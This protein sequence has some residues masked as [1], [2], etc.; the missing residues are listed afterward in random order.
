MSSDRRAGS[1]G[2]ATVGWYPGGI[3]RRVPSTRMRT[4]LPV[5]ALRRAG[6][7]ASV[8]LRTDVAGLDCVVFQ[9]AYDAPAIEWARRLRVSG[10]PTVFDLC[11]DHFDNPDDD[12][13]LRERAERLRTM[14][15]LVD[16]VT[17]SVPG[18]VSVVGHP[19]VHVVD[20]ALEFLPSA[21][22][23][24]RWAPWWRARRSEREIR[25][26]W[27]G[28]SG[29]VSPRTGM[30]CIEDAIP[31]LERLHRDRPVRLRVISNSRDIFDRHVARAA[32][33][34]EYREW[35][36]RGFVRSFVPADVCVIPITINASTLKKTANRVR[37][38]LLL[39]TPTVATRI[40]SY[41][42]YEPWVRFDDWATNVAA[43]VDDPEQARRDVAGARAHILD[44][45][46]DERL[47][48][49]WSAAI[50]DALGSVS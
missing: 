36:E 12:P 32:F 47:V 21:R 39:G 1:L 27:F 16:V 28:A 29:T 19:R 17:V 5:R 42:E 23:A 3:D 30:A 50:A 34:T 6:V 10:V 33:P 22:S 37:T 2:S 26:V 46:T 8:H 7:D 25:L 40:P 15:D 38:A 13:V 45:Y 14:V 31:D 35:T 9:K 43:T 24:H 11:D 4:Y 20:D 44:T 49:Q 41:E 18:L 48:E